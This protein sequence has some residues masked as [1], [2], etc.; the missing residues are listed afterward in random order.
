LLDFSPNIPVSWFA[1]V[2]SRFSIRKVNCEL[3]WFDYL[4]SSLPKE[5]VRLVVDLVENPLEDASQ[6]LGLP[7]PHQLLVN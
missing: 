2:E 1:L 6:G 5:S 7:H 4:A 3:L